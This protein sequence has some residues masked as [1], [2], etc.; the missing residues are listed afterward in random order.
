M[1]SYWWQCTRCGYSP[2]SFKSVCKSRG[3]VHFLRDELLL[4]KWDQELLVRQCPSCRERSLRITYEFPRQK[5]ETIRVLHIVGVDR[6]DYLPMMWET[7]PSPDL[8]KRWF[9]FKREFAN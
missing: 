1:P 2:P 8:T 9:D 7:S 5:K 4:A 3:I 6:G